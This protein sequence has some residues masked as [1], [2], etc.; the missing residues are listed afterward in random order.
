MIFFNKVVFLSTTVL[1]LGSGC[2]SAIDKQINYHEKLSNIH[3]FD[4]SQKL[5]DLYYFKGNTSKAKENY[6]DAAFSGNTEAMYKLALILG[7]EG[8]VDQAEIWVKKSSESGYNLAT[9]R[10]GIFYF[11][12]DNLA[13]AEKCF[14]KTYSLNIIDAIY[15][16]GRIAQKKKDYVTAKKYFKEAAMFNDANALTCL[17]DIYRSEKKYDKA[18][19]YYEKAIDNNNEFALVRLARLYFDIKNPKKA[20]LLLKKGIEN[21][22]E[23]FVVASVLLIQIYIK[24]K[25]FQKVVKIYKS[26]AKQR[27]YSDFY[28]SYDENYNLVDNNSFIY[29]LLGDITL[30]GYKKRKEAIKWY[31]KAADLGNKDA[32]ERLKK[33]I[34]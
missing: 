23:T 22:D 6:K 33:L 20:K 21:N 5:G 19:N 4:N 26:I 18:I 1:V 31:Q 17:G 16:L 12:N 9:L 15:Y 32:K 11:N 13:E 8:K 25:N 7:Y 3:S 10:L 14:K 34:K 30:Y 27:K 2:Q 24:E 28:K 29:L